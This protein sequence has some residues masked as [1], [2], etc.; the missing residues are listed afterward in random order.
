MKPIDAEGMVQAYLAQLGFD[1]SA[2]PLPPDFAERLPFVL[3]TRTG[4]QTYHV[5]ADLHIMSF[6]VYAPTWAQAMDAAGD[7]VEAVRS[8]RGLFTGGVQFYVP[9]CN[10]PYNNPDP[11]RADVPRVTFTATLTASGKE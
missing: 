10:M 3:V 4:G 1:C 11:N 5:A 6:D 8:M 2:T 7:A 9:D